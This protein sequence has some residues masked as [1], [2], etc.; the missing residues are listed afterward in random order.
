MFKRKPRWELYNGFLAIKGGMTVQESDALNAFIKL[1]VDSEMRLNW[2]Q[3]IHVLD[4]LKLYKCTCKT[5]ELCVCSCVKNTIKL[6]EDNN[7]WLKNG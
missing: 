4:A 7:P 3:N 2:K 1:K 5:N 6:I